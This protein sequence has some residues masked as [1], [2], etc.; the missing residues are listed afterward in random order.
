MEDN[1]ITIFYSKKLGIIKE[2]VGSERDFDWFGQEAEDYRVIYDRLVVDED[3]YIWQNYNNMIVKD[4]ALVM[5][6]S[7]IPDKY[8]EVIKGDDE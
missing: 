8:N 7:V 1:K 2:I 3:A 4:G 5:M 6:Q